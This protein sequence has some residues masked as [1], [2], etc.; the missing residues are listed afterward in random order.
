MRAANGC[1]LSPAPCPSDLRH[2]R[3]VVRLIIMTFSVTLAWSAAS[4]SMQ[5]PE[6]VESE[7]RAQSTPT[8]GAAAP[9]VDPEKPSTRLYDEIEV[10][11]RV[12]DLVGIAAT[13]S[14]GVTG[15]RDLEARPIQ[16]TAEVVE[17][18]PGMVAT[19]HSGDGKANQYFVRGFNLDHGTDFAISVAG[20]PVNMPSHGHGQGYTDLNF[21]IPEVIE[22]VRFRKGTASTSGG[23]FSAAGSAD[24][25]LV[26]VLDQGF[27]E[28][29]LGSYSFERAV[30]GQ[31]FAVG[32]GT[33]TT[34]L[35]VHRNDGPWQRGNDFERFNGFLR[36]NQGD[37]ARGWSVTAL[38]YDGSWLS[39][40]QIPLRAVQGGEI[41]R[42]GLID[43]GPRGE[44]S[45]YSLSATLRRGGEKTASTFTIYGVS[46]DL[47][48]ISNFTYFLEN[49]DRGDQFEQVDERSIF[50]FD[51]RQRRS[52]QWGS[53]PVDWSL[54]V[55]ARYD[56]IDNGLFRTRDLARF[57]TVRSDSIEQLSLGPYAEVEA[58]WSDVV[59]TTFG[60]GFDVYEVDV[61]SDLATNSG[62]RDDSLLSPKLSVAFGPWNATE[63]YASVGYG[64]HSNDAR[65][66]TIRVDPVSGEPV[67]RVEPLVRAI[68]SEIGVRSALFDGLQSTVTVYR[69]DLDSELV[70]VGDG[71]A[72]EASGAS[73]R[74]GIEWTNAWRVIPM[75][76]LELDAAWVDAELRDEP[77]GF[78]EIPGAVESVVSAGFTLRRERWLAA[79]R[80][81]YFSGYPLTGDGSVKAGANV[82]LNAR[83]SR[84]FANGF[85]VTVE[86][87]NLL[88]RNDSDV[89]YY[90]AS[91]LPGEPAGGVEDVHFH[92]VEKPSIRIGVSYRF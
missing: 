50:G 69:L 66:A 83:L 12:D 56:D 52:S 27:M 72:T 15:R 11:E 53:V 34:A 91:R 81:R 29:S 79:A 49:P 2:N 54:G 21:L 74:T 6:P 4:L 76:T 60:L 57:A 48:L 55:R 44:S 77:Q 14:E 33:L 88:D 61:V 9:E 7:S 35:E 10:K 28:L 18:V 30:A 8:D 43:D 71:G 22:R 75:I 1:F 20:I 85:A 92:P 64:F 65:G 78:R 90:Y 24:I 13:A 59:R 19:Q 39:T 47:S 68:G 38:G 46:Y 5:K 70:F 73:R 37:A 17:T 26:S 45:R 32:E 62:Q 82:G 89:E 84:T 51:L 16:R 23:D 80:V 67:D 58:H 86:G 63:L 31:S 40:D 25:E 41:D 3:F 87:F 42:F 36:Y